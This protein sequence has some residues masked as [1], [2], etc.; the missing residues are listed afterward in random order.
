MRAAATGAL[1]AE[2]GTTVVCSSRRA[3]GRRTAAR[4]RRTRPA[5]ASRSPLP[6]ACSPSRAG[7]R[8]RPARARP[9]T[10]ADRRRHSSPTGMVHRPLIRGVI[11][12]RTAT[13]TARQAC[14]HGV[15]DGLQRAAPRGRGCG[16][17]DIY[18]P[19]HGDV[20]H[21][22]RVRC[23][24]VE[25]Q[26]LHAVHLEQRRV[27]CQLRRPGEPA[28]QHR[29]ARRRRPRACAGRG[30]VRQRTARQRAAVG[31]QRGG[32]RGQECRALRAP[33]VRVVDRHQRERARLR[34]RLR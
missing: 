11:A 6:S 26:P 16:Q 31:R 29:R 27:R 33:G 19:V 5:R 1:P 32:Q 34:R 17:H 23:R 25:P 10:A 9:D 3:P 7:G 21:D 20:A 22:F 30:R 14:A 28:A 8:G 2:T 18:G 24:I 4:A 12:Q 13:V 15:R